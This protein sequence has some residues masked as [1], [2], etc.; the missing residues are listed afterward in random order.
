MA[1]QMSDVQRHRAPRTY[2]SAQVIDATPIPLEQWET[3][4]G[5]RESV[6][7]V[8]RRGARRREYARVGELFQRRDGLWQ[9]DVLRVRPPAPRWVRPAI[10]AGSVLATLAMLALLGVW[11]F[12]ALGD[13]L[14]GAPAA[15]W[16]GGGIVL[17]GIGLLAFRR[18]VTEV[19]VR[20]R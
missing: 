7:T 2:R 12:A 11:A 9:V 10:I 16:V 5:F 6:L 13:A 15:F 19:I 20:V 14:A 4:V 1:H 8:L 17:T 3:I 18:P